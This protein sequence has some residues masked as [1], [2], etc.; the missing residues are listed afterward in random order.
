M[1]S[2]CS[3]YFS[4]VSSS[5]CIKWGLTCSVGHLGS[6]VLGLS[7][8]DRVLVLFAIFCMLCGYVLGM[9]CVDSPCSRLLTIPHGCVINLA[10][11]F[12]LAI[13][14]LVSFGSV[15]GWNLYCSPILALL[16]SS[17]LSDHVPIRG[18]GVLTL[19]SLNLHGSL[20]L[21]NSLLSESSLLW[22]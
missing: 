1:L 20:V 5:L 16:L 2:V 14:D 3:C 21:S 4:L 10:N 12:Q 13:L 19:Y 15:S 8:V 11:R 17:F 6:F 7:D 22:C 18:F 9:R